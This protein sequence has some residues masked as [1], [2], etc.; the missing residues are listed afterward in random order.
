[1]TFL[2]PPF[3]LALTINL[4][5]Y[6]L[7]LHLT[8]IC[9]FVENP[10][11]YHALVFFEKQNLLLTLFLSSLSCVYLTMVS[12]YFSASV[13][14]K[15]PALNTKEQPRKHIKAREFNTSTLIRDN[16]LTFLGRVTNLQEQL[17]G[18]LITALP[19]KGVSKAK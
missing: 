3:S 11:R 2:Y 8:Y 15:G 1:M 13:K 4:A 17:V 9:I 19:K 6:P 5:N 12:S 14:G 7:F 10:S 16:V 18:D